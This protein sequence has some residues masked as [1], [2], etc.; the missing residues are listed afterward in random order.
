[1]INISLFTSLCTKMYNNLSVTVRGYLATRSYWRWVLTVNIFSELEN[2]HHQFSNT[3]PT[4]LLRHL[5]MFLH[6]DTCA[7][8][9]VK[10][11]VS[12]MTLKFQSRFLTPKFYFTINNEASYG[13]ISHGFEAPKGDAFTL[14]NSQEHTFQFGN[15]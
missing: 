12:C 1:M 8:K 9:S 13:D 3:L 10:K 2:I 14:W 4:M 6:L 11:A 7:F 15:T 5:V